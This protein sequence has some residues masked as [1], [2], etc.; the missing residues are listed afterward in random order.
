MVR[1]LGDR[2]LDHDTSSWIITPLVLIGCFGAA[3]LLSH[4]A[5]S[6]VEVLTGGR[7]PSKAKRI[8]QPPSGK[9]T[10][11]NPTSVPAN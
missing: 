7:T 8:S 10:S 2:V 4:F 11:G 6:V 5:P 1:N 3:F 9:S